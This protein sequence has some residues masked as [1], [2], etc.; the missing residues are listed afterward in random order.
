MKRRILALVVLLSF[1]GAI[2][3]HA[4]GDGSP[5][6]MIADTLLVRPACFAATIIGGTFFVISLPFAALSKSV[7][8]TAATLVGIPARATFTRP[9]GEFDTLR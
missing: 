4:T 6:A 8:K 3:S 5:E 9:L 1:S 2:S 7:D